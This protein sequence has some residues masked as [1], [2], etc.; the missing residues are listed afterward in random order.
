[1]VKTA[2]SIPSGYRQS[3]PFCSCRRQARLAHV[4]CLS[5]I[6]WRYLRRLLTM[7]ECTLSVWRL[8]RMLIME[9]AMKDQAEV[10]S[11]QSP[12][13]SKWQSIRAGS[14]ATSSR[15]PPNASPTSSVMTSRQLVASTTSLKRALLAIMKPRQLS[16]AR[17]PGW[18]TTLSSK[19]SQ[20]PTLRTHPWLRSTRCR[21]SRRYRSRHRHR[22]RLLYWQL[23]R[24]H[25]RLCLS[26]H[27]SSLR[28]FL[29]GHCH[30]SKQS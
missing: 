12:T 23:L 14:L 13:L 26:T 16:R 10:R 27:A 1:M 17:S 7:L 24:Q 3:C 8:N 21:L 25:L 2:A 11:L 19:T 5:Q 4:A 22:T 6:H 18:F 20:W 29:T 28:S 9:M 15:P 30:Q